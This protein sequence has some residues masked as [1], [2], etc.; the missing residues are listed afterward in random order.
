M[1]LTKFSNTCIFYIKYI[2]AFLHLET[3]ESMSAL[4]L[5]VNLSSEIANKKHKNVKN[6]ALNRSLFT[7]SELKQGEQ[8]LSGPTPT[9]NGHSF[10][11]LSVKDSRKH[12]Y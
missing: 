2:T 10:A 1:Y 3:P 7:I 9:R 11:C 5:G 6:T 4:G 8:A 12:E